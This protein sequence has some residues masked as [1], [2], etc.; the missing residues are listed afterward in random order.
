[1]KL[2]KAVHEF[3]LDCRVR[4][5]AETVS[6][7]E[8][9]LNLLT[10]LAGVS[11]T[12]TVLAFTPDLV[13]QYFHTL[14]QKGLSM[15]TLHRRR[16]SLNEFSKWGLRR[17]LW[18]TSPM[19]D[20]PDIKR[21]RHLPRPF[22]PAEREKL[23]G[24]ELPLQERVIRALLYYTGLRVSTICRIKLSDI[25]TDV[26][27]HPVKI[28]TLGKG[29]RELWVYVVPQLASVLQDYLLAKSD[30][31]PT[32]YILAQSGNRPWHRRMIERRTRAW[33][34]ALGIIKCTPH[35]FRHTFG[36][37]L[38]ERGADIRKI[39]KLMGH[40]DISTTMLYVDVTDRDLEETAWLLAEEESPT[41]HGE[42]ETPRDH[43]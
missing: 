7:Y 13:R 42:T 10:S 12:D 37:R 5:A 33:G 2:S 29:R 35:R 11:A 1:M 27:M 43:A 21:P 23:L 39:Q 34:A 26:D 6:G 20:A 40:A 9:D 38:L 41:R 16:A 4:L 32:S 15:A 8:S 36:T 25:H 31:D 18:V 24:L 14:S 22:S 17:K 3:I 30:L 28:R 19:L